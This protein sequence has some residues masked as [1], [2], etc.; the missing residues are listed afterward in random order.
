[1]KNYI[2]PDIEMI[3]ISGND[4]ITVSTGTQTKPEV[5]SPNVDMGYG[6]QFD[7]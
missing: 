6:D 2:S 1:M 5:E 4:V 7:W 3:D